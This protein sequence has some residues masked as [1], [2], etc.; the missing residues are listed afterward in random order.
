MAG[1]RI[2]RKFRSTA[3][4]LADP[5]TQAHALFRGRRKGNHS[6]ASAIKAMLKN[7]V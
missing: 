2:P 5:Q 1:S 3:G 6:A 4:N 7:W